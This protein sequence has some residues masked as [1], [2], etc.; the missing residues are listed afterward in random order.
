MAPRRR[1][2]AW[3][4]SRLV[5]GLVAALPACA[6]N[7]EWIYEK[8]RVTPAQLDHDKTVCRKIAPARGLFKSFESEQVEREGFNRCM[9][10]RGYTFKVVPLP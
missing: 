6:A 8:P 5:W 10:S 4:A 1:I 3:L 9:Q 7:Q 2:S